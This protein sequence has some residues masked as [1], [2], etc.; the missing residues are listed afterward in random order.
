M[1]SSL[2]LGEIPHHIWEPWNNGNKSHRL[3]PKEEPFPLHLFVVV[4]WFLPMVQVKRESR[5]NGEL[6]AEKIL[7]DLFQARNYQYLLVC[8]AQHP[9][10]HIWEHSVLQICRALKVNRKTLNW[11]WY[12]ARL[13][14]KTED[15]GCFNI[16]AYILEDRISGSM[17]VASPRTDHWYT[18][19]HLE[20]RW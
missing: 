6:R 18:L 1:P 2:G 13:S 3:S 15:S 20:D 7:A 8:Q 19:W 9:P 14:R 5:W 16:L 4:W 10:G 17:K 12:L 11:I